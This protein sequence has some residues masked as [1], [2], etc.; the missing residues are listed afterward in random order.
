MTRSI[1]L[2]W[3]LA[4]V[5]AAAGTLACTKLRLGDEDENPIRVR[6]K[7]L[8]FD[9]EGKQSSWVPDRRDGRRWRLKKNKHGTNVYE[10]IAY[11]TNSSGCLDPLKATTVDV[12]FE[13]AGSSKRFVFT[14]DEEEAGSGNEPVVYPQDVTMSADNS[15][16]TK[17]LRIAD[18]PQGAITRITVTPPSGSPIT[19]EFPTDRRVLVELCRNQC[20]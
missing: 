12:V 18:N 5:A 10:V 14:I 9:T 13:V 7:I 17:K 6:N 20:S 2:L 19:C 3:I 8:H 11:G 4:A 1:K 16:F 15:G